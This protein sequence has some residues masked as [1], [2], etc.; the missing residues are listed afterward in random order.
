[1]RYGAVLHWL[2]WRWDV[3]LWF[4]IGILEAGLGLL[5]VV[6]VEHFGDVCEVPCSGS[7]GFE[8]S[9]LGS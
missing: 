1:M 7:G 9:G 2:F 8:H 5:V 4:A 6:S 3:H